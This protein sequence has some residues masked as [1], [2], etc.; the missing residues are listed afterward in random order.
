MAARSI[1][2]AA[3]L[4]L[5][6]CYASNVVAREDRAVGDRQLPEHWTAATPADLAGLFESV[7]VTG[8]A[9]VSL[10]SVHYWF[11]G[12]GRYTGAALVDGDDGMAFQT[13]TGRW[14]LTDAG[15]ALDDA[16]PARCEAAPGFLRIGTAGG[17]L[18][19]RRR[20]LR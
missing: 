11:G 9:A 18:V 20:E 15:L 8:D 1:A 2:L 6:G 7:R 3:A 4:P 13:L 5:L 12:D 19:L 16:P 17:E 10:R 14:A